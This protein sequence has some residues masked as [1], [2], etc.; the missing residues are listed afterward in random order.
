MKVQTQLIY[1]GE[2][3]DS[4]GEAS[5][6]D[7]GTA[8]TQEDWFP[9]TF[10]LFF[11]VHVKAQ[12]TGVQNGKFAFPSNRKRFSGVGMV[13]NSNSIRTMSEEMDHIC[14]L[15]QTKNDCKDAW[16]DAGM[17]KSFAA[18]TEK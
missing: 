4:V 16:A 10:S 8:R 15:Y 5:S 11:K 18:P 14:V 9:T 13:A 3:W 7:G 17:K 1:Q 6:K 12:D 2:D